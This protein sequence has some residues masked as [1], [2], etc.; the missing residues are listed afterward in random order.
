MLK[1]EHDQYQMRESVLNLE[2]YLGFLIHNGIFVYISYNETFVFVRCQS[3]M[4]IDESDMS[5]IIRVEN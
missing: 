4:K 2:F 5:Q 1:H 3:S